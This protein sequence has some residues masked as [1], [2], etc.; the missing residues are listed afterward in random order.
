[1][2]ERLASETIW[3][4]GR[5]IIS[6]CDVQHIE[7]FEQAATQYTKWTKRITVV[8]KST[9]REKESSDWENAIYLYDADSENFVADYCT[10]R[11]EIDPVQ[12]GPGYTNSHAEFASHGVCETCDQ[13]KELYESAGGVPE[14]AYWLMTELFVKLHGGRDVCIG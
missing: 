9:V 11:N 7:T 5:V 12:Q 10:F 14:R 13:L 6:M 1:M 8:M 2:K 4:N 3:S